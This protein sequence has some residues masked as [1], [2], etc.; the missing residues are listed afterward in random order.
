MGFL[1]SLT[2]APKLKTTQPILSAFRTVPRWIISERGFCTRNGCKNKNTR[3]TRT[4]LL[5]QFWPVP[6]VEALVA[7]LPSAS[8]YLRKPA[9]WFWPPRALLL[10][11]YRG[12]SSG[13]KWRRGRGGAGGK[14]HSWSSHLRVGARRGSAAAAD[15]IRQRVGMV[16]AVERFLHSMKD[17][18]QAMIHT[19]CSRCFSELISA[20]CALYRRSCSWD[21]AVRVFLFSRATGA[22]ERQRTDGDEQLDIS[23]CFEGGS[24]QSE[25]FSRNTSIT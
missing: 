6:P 25:A 9:W 23:T 19:S 3:D 7:S 22:P 13:R 5:P 10:A 1:P 20:V 2:V 16:V 21:R 4:S 14:V 8:R 18:V 11:H 15:A 12:F 24:R 17:F